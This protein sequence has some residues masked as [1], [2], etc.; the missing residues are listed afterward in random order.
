MF[1]S[2]LIFLRPSMLG[3]YKQQSCTCTTTVADEEKEKEL[4]RIARNAS[5][6]EPPTACCQSGCANCVFIVWAEALTSKMD[7]AG[8]EIAEKILKL[9]E[10][11][12]M[13]AY[14]EME[15][16]LRGLKKQ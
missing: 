12:S 10:D 14:L 6:D 16:R 3:R 2:K 9:V 11:P 13:K 4:E 5:I 8:P 7:N 15:L 1:I